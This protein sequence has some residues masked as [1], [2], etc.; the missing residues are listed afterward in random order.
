MDRLK[1]GLGIVP[2][3]G[4]S[5]FLFTLGAAASTAAADHLRV[6][7]DRFVTA[8]G[9]AFEWRGVTAFRLAELIATGRE[10]DADAY[11]AWAQAQKLTIVR[12]LAMAHNLF[13]LPPDRGRAAMARL[14]TMAAARGLAVEIVALADTASFQFDIDAHMRELGQICARAGLCTIEIAN[15][16]IHATQ[17]PRVHDRTYLAALRRLIPAEVPGSLG[18]GTAGDAPGAGDYVTVH[19]PRD[20]GWKHVAALAEGFALR[21]RF[22]APVI[23]D[24]PIGA[25]NEAV[26][27]RRDA[28]PERFRAAALLSQMAGL[29]ATFHYDGGL[30]ATVPA[31]R[32]EA[33]FKAWRS[34]WDLL[35]R[36]PLTGFRELT[37]SDP[38]A[39]TGTA[40]VTGVWIA[41]AGPEIWVLAIGTSGAPRAS[42]SKGW[43]L[44]TAHVW[45][46]SA[47]WSLSQSPTR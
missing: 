37:P 36:A 10:R 24:E 13:E 6:S 18:L 34:A 40:T 42:A 33:C 8:D 11:L 41:R 1:I 5:V 7:G 15:E 16:P 20:D 38:I 3:I 19:F 9:T 22:K 28:D 21:Q 43:R 45:R 32:Q 27:G 39:L 31:G 2:S 23:N 25:A 17:D 44:R 4:L 12:V 26:P 29:G 47:L 14:L 46:S 30:Q 35:P